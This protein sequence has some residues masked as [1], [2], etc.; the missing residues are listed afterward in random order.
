MTLNHDTFEYEH[1]LNIGKNKG[2]ARLWMEK[3]VLTDSGIH[4]GDRFNVTYIDGYFTNIGYVKPVLLI[5]VNPNGKRK[6]SGKLDRPIIDMTAKTLQPLF[7][8]G[9]RARIYS[10]GEGVLR[11]TKI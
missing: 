9:D 3:G 1:E 10:K 11:I 8:I 7:E 5:E 6:V 2:K 4:H